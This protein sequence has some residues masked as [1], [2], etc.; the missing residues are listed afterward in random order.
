MWVLLAA[1]VLVLAA[2][3]KAVARGEDDSL[4]VSD[5]QAAAVPH[6][7]AVAQKLEKIDRWGKTATIVAVVYGL[8]L[9]ATYLYQV[10]TAS[11]T[12][13]QG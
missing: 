13:I 6:Q 4:H 7:I 9:L 12:T 5:G 10:W 3:R 8:A 2:W 11:S 1:T